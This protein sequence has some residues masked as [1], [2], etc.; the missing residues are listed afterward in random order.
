MRREV[1]AARLAQQELGVGVGPRQGLEGL[2][3]RAHVLAD[4]RVRAA[5]R[6]DGG[7]AVRRQRRVARQE[8]GVLAREDVVRHDGQRVLLP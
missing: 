2:E 6:L 4:R 5:P 1:V 7:D 3:V 8:L